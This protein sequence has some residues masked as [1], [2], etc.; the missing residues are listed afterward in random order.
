M[1]P[2]M[3]SF[4]NTSQ[5]IR[6][7]GGR[8]RSFDDLYHVL[9]SAPWWADLLVIVGLFL[10]SNCVFA[11]AYFFTGG[12]AG[13]QPGSLVDTFFFSVQT[14]GTVGYGQMYPVSRAA[15]AVM[16]LEVVTGIIEVA[17]VTGLL[18]A[19][20][21]IPRS[22]V[23]FAE[24]AVLSMFDGMPTLMFRVA[25]ER[26]N[27]VVEAQVRVSLLREESTAEG[28][29]V[30]RMRDLKLARERSPAFVRTWLVMHPVAEDSPL[31]G[32]TAESLAT[33][34]A[35]VIVILTGIDGTSGQTIHARH[36]YASDNIHFGARYVDMMS[37]LPDGRVQ[38]DFRQFNEVTTAP[39]RGTTDK[40]TAPAP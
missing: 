18:F 3:R 38:L 34:D 20:F 40:T 6:I 4:F 36:S 26:A 13:A 2:G 5:A 32:Q 11:L 7:V 8:P 12:V 21:S 15:S 1:S 10:L 35:Q 37:D 28:H 25:N 31:K 9:L 39:P 27:H 30:Y 33:V 23:I 22:R 17:L 16:T 29:N 24:R 14:L 19:K